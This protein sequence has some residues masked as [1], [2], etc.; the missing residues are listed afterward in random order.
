MCPNPVIEL[1][2]LNDKTLQKVLH[3]IGISD[4]CSRII[5]IRVVSHVFEFFVWLFPSA[6]DLSRAILFHVQPFSHVL[7]SFFHVY[8][9]ELDAHEVYWCFAQQHQWHLLAYPAIKF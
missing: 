2:R 5:R 9:L 1:P 6:S 7:L 3:H 4:K 8:R